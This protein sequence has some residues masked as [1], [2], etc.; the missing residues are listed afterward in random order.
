MQLLE[1]L[2]RKRRRLLLY[3]IR[4]RLVYTPWMHEDV[5]HDVFVELM[6]R[7]DTSKPMWSLARKIANGM[8]LDVW[9]IAQRRAEIPAHLPH[10]WD[11]EA[12]MAAREAAQKAE[13]A[14]T[15]DEVNLLLC[16][17]QRRPPANVAVKIRIAKRK[18]VAALTPIVATPSTLMPPTG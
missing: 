10:D 6:E 7:Y 14:L 13:R 15:R 3:L 9:R 18:A 11:M 16:E 8:C 12:W 2:Y 5:L 1:A 17:W 4:R